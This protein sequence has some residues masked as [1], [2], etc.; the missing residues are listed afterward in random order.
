MAL[1]VFKFAQA[2]ESGGNPFVKLQDG[3]TVQL[4]I[5]SQPTCGWEVFAD[6]RP[7]R[8]PHDQKKPEGTP[9]TDERAKPFLCFIVYQYTDEP[10][11]KI[12]QFSQQTIIKQ[13]EVLFNGG[14]EHWSTY[15]LTIRRKGSGLDTKYTVSGVM[16]P[17]EDN[18]ID[19]AS[20]ADEYVDLSALF[21]ND[22]PIIQPLPEISVEQAKQETGNDPF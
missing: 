10:G 22:S 2:A 13:M 16:V 4:R 15:V 18:L 1:D 9:P 6:G 11:V 5:I 12:W 17:L 19:F 20:K 14:K 3:D 21:V 8:W 7:Y